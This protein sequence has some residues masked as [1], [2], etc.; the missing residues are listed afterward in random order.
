M[1]FYNCPDIEFDKECKRLLQNI[2]FYDVL[3]SDRSISSHGLEPGTPFLDR[4]FV[5]CYLSIPISIRNY[6]FKQPKNHSIKEKFL[7]NFL[8]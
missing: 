1:Y 6:F 2:H 3:R 7:L 8:Y 4:E 5:E